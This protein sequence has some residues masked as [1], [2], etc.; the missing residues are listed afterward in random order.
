M[1][2]KKVAIIAGCIFGCA[3]LFVVMMAFWVMSVRNGL[4]R[5][6]NGIEAI[7]ADMQ[8]VHASAYQ[9]MKMQDVAVDKYGDMVLEAI[10]VAISGRYG[11]NGAQAAFTWI[12]EENPTIEPEIME[13]LQQ[14]IEAG[15]N[16]F[17]ASQRD[18]I[19]R[20]R[21][22]KDSL[23]VFPNNVVAS[24]FGFP[25]IDMTLAEQVISTGQT[26]ADFATGE[27]SDPLSNE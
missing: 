4:V 15:Y 21:V 3:C 19:D 18:K 7:Q 13:K 20:V 1:V 8:N 17:E 12:K 2:M 14:A 6:E 5:Q 25:T 11:E 26:K 22:Y 16:K 9:Q 23:E 10:D 27:L 24:V